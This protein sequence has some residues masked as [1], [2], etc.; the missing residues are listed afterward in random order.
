MSNQNTIIQSFT[1]N[2]KIVEKSGTFL[3][4]TMYTSDA[5]DSSDRTIYFTKRESGQE[6]LKGTM[7]AS[8]HCSQNH[9]FIS[10]IDFVDVK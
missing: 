7:T 9:G 6:V 2:G 5:D 3:G 4:F 10:D 1:L 8:A